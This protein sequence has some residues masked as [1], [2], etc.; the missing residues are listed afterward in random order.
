MNIGYDLINFGSTQAEG[1]TQLTIGGGFRTRLVKNVDVGV[2][3]EAGVV[4]PVG[5]FEGRVTADLIWRF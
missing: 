1:T 4:D 5:I 2:A 3:Y